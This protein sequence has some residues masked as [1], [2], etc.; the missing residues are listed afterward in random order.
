[1][2]KIKDFY[3]LKYLFLLIFFY[4]SICVHYLKYGALQK[5]QN[6]ATSYHHVLQIV[7]I[8]TNRSPY[9]TFKQAGIVQVKIKH[10]T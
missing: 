9:L 10:H 4:L 5:T 6:V 7:I 1:M 3:R 8:K 2:G